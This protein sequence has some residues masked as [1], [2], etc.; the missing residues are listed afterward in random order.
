VSGDRQAPFDTANPAARRA[1]RRA[2][3]RRDVLRCTPAEPARH[4][5]PAEPARDATPDKIA[6]EEP[7][8]IR[9][10]GDPLATIMRTP[11]EDHALAVGFLH[12]EGIIH[13][14]SDLGRVFHCGRPSDPGYG[15]LIDVA[16]GPG[17][18]LAPELAGATR[19][20]TLIAAACGVCG[21]ERIDDLIARLGPV[22]RQVRV[23]AADI[24]ASLE[25][26]RERQSAFARSGGMHGALACDSHGRVLAISE[27]VGRHNAVDKVVGHLLYAG[28]LSRR[29][30]EAALLAVS[31]RTSFEIVQKAAA[32]RI[33]VVVS[34]SAPTSLAI[35]L[36]DAIGV[37]LIGFA[38]DGAF[39]VYA[40][41]ARIAWP[42]DSL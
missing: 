17:T 6:V 25:H 10:A 12:S 15:N 9:V 22:E 2:L 11:G 32:A 38:R 31:G 5:T 27:D 23:A 33:P 24:S 28:Q 20:G 36:A 7:L 13:D 8:E 29:V 34:V 30:A 26:L 42:R 37:T 35:D 14:L 18:A 19:R 16:P 4:A 40:H 39:N 1:E 21:R 41:A 3:T